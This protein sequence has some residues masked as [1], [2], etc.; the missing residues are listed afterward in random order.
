MDGK[1]P[2]TYNQLW[3]PSHARADTA[4]FTPY[5]SEDHAPPSHLA[6]PRTGTLTARLKLPPTYRLPAPSTAI[7][8]EMPFKPFAV[9]PGDH[10]SS[11]ATRGARSGASLVWASSAGAVVPA[12]VSLG[13][14]VDTDNSVK[15]CGGFLVHPLPGADD[16]ASGAAMAVAASGTSM[17]T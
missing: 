4:P 12:A 1:Y 11:P 6:I 9:S 10:F 13:V 16:D 7:A 2:P 17:I 14:F 8:R 3:M 5:P 15:A